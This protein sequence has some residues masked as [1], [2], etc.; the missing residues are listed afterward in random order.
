MAVELFVRKQVQLASVVSCR[1]GFV[2]LEYG[3]VVGADPGGV[4]AASTPR[5]D[6]DAMA[7]TVIHA[8]AILEKTKDGEKFNVDDDGS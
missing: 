1:P 7:A 6:S 8:N 3:D 5:S 2:E 4:V